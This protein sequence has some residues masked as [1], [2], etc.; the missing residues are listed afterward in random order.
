MSVDERLERD[1]SDAVLDA[2]LTVFGEHGV[3]RARMADIAERADVARATL[4]YHHRSKEALLVALLHRG[5]DELAA[6]VTA[7]AERQPP[8]EVIRAMVRWALH[9][10]ALY[11]LIVTE[12]PT[13]VPVPKELVAR[14]D[15]DVV[16]PMRACIGRGIAAGALRDC[17]P[18]VVAP[19]LLGQVDVVVGGSLLLGRPLDGDAVEAELVELTRRALAP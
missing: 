16:A 7:T 1:Q 9:N 18:E 3:A 6:L 19:A 17:D 4:Y 15:R 5:L 2:A 10:E 12:L 13:V 8:H 11:R 14:L